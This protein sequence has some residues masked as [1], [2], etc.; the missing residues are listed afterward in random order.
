MAIAGAQR[1]Q[2]LKVLILSLLLDLISFTFILPLFPSL[3][4]FYRAQD[5]SPDSLLNRIFHYLNAYKN[6]FARPIDSRYDIVLL[7][8]A[9]GS[10]FSLLQAFAA[11]VIG[12]LSD[13]HGRRR[14][15][16]TSMLGNLLSVALW[17]SATD[18]RMF[19]ASR[20]VGGLSEANVQMANAIVADITDEERRGSSMALIGACFSVAFTFGPALGAAL[21]SINMVAENPFIVAA[22][23]SF[24]LIF[25]ETVYLWT[26]LPETHPR[27]TTLQMEGESMSA[28]KSEAS[29]KKTEEKSSA[30]VKRTHIN[31]PVL[32]NALHF[33]FLLPFSGL[34]FS[35]PFLTTTLYAG[36]ATTASPAALNGRL[37]SLMG[38]IA[39]LLQ[40]TLVRRLPPLITLR[41]GVVA[42]TISFFCLARVSSPSGLYAAGALLA[43]TT[44]TVVT[45]LNSL[46]SFEAQDADRGAVMGRLR[47]WGQAGRAT[48]PIVFCS[49][50]WWAGREAAYT[51]GGFAMCVV[52]VAA[53]GL[54]K[55]PVVHKKME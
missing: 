18:F 28:E 36:S 41:A 32:L 27:L 53:F 5:P 26:C 14:A 21:S 34:E 49:L 43:V 51:A 17:V 20:I 37:L 46:G 38:L 39:S 9:L 30:P 6:S 16:L 45:S 48:G 44:A 1:K 8:G 24:V 25:I 7:G 40:G 52:T 55:S 50:F 19:L 2:V 15:L 29:N 42:C 12:R 47:G 13:R 31:S 33:L 11:P 22:I 10:L 4:S 35:L 54:L 23:V 3:L